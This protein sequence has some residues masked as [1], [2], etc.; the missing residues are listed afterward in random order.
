MASLCSAKSL[1]TKKLPAFNLVELLVVLAIIGILVLMALP[2][3]APLITRAKSTE[4]QLQLG[5]L[6]ML[7]KTYYYQHSKYSESID[8]L[9]FEQELLVTEGGQ[10]NYSIE[11]IE[12]TPTTFKATATSVVDFNN[13]GIYNVW[14]IDQDKK[15][16]EIQRD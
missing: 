5:H 2:N 11:I 13:N 3:L 7:Q 9:G 16:K 14:E 12:V 15:L 4:A 6:H 10:A 8:E 1:L